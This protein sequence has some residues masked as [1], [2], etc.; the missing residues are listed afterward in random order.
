[1]PRQKLTDKVVNRKPPATGYV[2]LF[3]TLTPGLALRITAK[4]KRSYFITTRVNGTQIKHKLDSTEKLTL[5]QARDMARNVIREAGEGTH[6]KE[7]RLR[8]K[9]EAERADSNTFR[10]VAEKYLTAPAG[11]GTGEG[12]AEGL[13]SKPDIERQLE[14]DLYPV[15]GLKRI[16]DITREDIE[17]LL[18]DL[19]KI[20]PIAANR[21]LGVLRRV[22][23]WAT[24]GKRRREYGIDVPPTFGV[25]PQATE[26]KRDRTLT[27]DELARLWKASGKLGQPFSHWFKL[28]IL[29][30]NRRNE[31]GGMR[32]DE[33]E[34]HSEFGRIWIIPG[35]RTKNKLKHMVPLVPL[36]QSILEDIV[37]INDYKH[38]F[39]TALRGDKPPSGWSKIKQR[40]N[41]IVVEEA[42]KAAGE[43]IDPEKH[44]IK[45][46][47]F[48]DIR[49]TVSTMMN[50]R[51]VEPHIVEAVL[52]HVSGDAKRG[53]AG[54]YNH[55]QYMPARRSALELWAKHIQTITTENVVEL[56]KG[57]A[58]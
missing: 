26:R 5:A 1:M 3:D 44:E 20:K 19:F 15:L 57:K 30:G 50:E 14:N 29:T 58:W 9:I 27:E 28:L 10:S 46:W 52:N 51:E 41:K 17:D 6:P 33:I 8:A 40:L 35:S 55:A 56:L 38:T 21:A 42:A 7:A 22:F 11:K 39:T 13:R 12:G 31:V 16:N 36:A 48:H 53:V 47:R 43:S 32:W 18:E 23:K 25:E 2:E 4:N 37:R 24:K 54:T 49:R 34:D 45:D